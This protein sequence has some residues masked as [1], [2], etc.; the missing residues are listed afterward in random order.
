MAY[1][2]INTNEYPRYEGDI[3]LIDPQ[4]NSSLPLPNGWFVV[5][6]TSHP[7]YSETQT[8]KEGVPNLVDGEYYQNW[9]VIDL[10]EDQILQKNTPKPEESGVKYYIWDF[11]KKE[12]KDQRFIAE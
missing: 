1:I 4:W 9:I 7:E 3:L 5:N 10:S 11:D 8:I 6:E 12:W 2:N